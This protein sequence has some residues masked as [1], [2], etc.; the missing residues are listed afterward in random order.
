MNIIRSC[1]CGSRIQV[2][3]ITTH[4]DHRS[5]ALAAAET[6]MDPWEQTHAR[7]ADASFGAHL[8]NLE[9]PRPGQLRLVPLGYDRWVVSATGIGQYISSG[10]VS[11]ESGTLY[12]WSEDATQVEMAFGP[13]MWVRVEAERVS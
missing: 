7:H 12:L 5:E 2:T 4:E 13:G 8:T 10:P 3:H 1:P 11:V 6:V 9:A